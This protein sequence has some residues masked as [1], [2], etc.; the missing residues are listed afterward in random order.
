MLSH[1]KWA[2]TGL[3]ALMVVALLLGALAW[4]AKPPK[5]PPEP[6]PPPPVTYKITWL[7][8][9]GGLESWLADMNDFGDV[10]GR[11]ATSTGELHPFLNQVQPAGTRTIDDLND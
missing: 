1:R 6:P 10:V 8:T 9:L 5:P 7:G 11:S 4:A 2:R 3:A